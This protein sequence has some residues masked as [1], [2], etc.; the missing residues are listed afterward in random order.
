MVLLLQLTGGIT[1]RSLDCQSVVQNMRLVQD[2]S[3]PPFYIYDVFN[4]TAELMRLKCS[5]AINAFSVS[6]SVLLLIPI[7]GIISWYQSFVSQAKSGPEWRIKPLLL[8]RQIKLLLPKRRRL[9]LFQQ[10]WLSLL[11]HLP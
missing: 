3:P 4:I 2:M 5:S 10:P 1:S 7:A 6:S 11:F 8:E 9:H